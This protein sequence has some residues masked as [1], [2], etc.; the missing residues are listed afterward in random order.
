MS[1][2]KIGG[3]FVAAGLLFAVGSTLQADYQDEVLADEPFAYWRLGEADPFSPAEN[4]GTALDVINGTYVGNVLLE[5]CGLLF[6]D[7]DTAGRFN[8]LDTE[9]RIPDSGFINTGGP[10]RARTI[11]LWFNAESINPEPERG[12]LYEEGGTTRGLNV[13][14]EQ[15]DGQDM[16][17]MTGWNR[18]EEFWGVI[19]VSVE[20]EE[21]KSTTRSWCSM[22]PTTGSSG[23]LT[24]GSP[25]IWTARSS[26]P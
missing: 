12:V 4:I 11:E 15:V 21:G 3:A 19:G 18:A 23:I 7:D 20:I 13:Y 26:T 24:A 25:G 9:I 10:F 22:P 16:L 8:G 1:R 17:F 6:D 5:E 2:A 14:V